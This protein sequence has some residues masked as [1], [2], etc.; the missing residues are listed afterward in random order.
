[1]Y[2]PINST[3]TQ[4]SGRKGRKVMGF[5]FADNLKPE[6]ACDLLQ[7]YSGW[8]HDST[9]HSRRPWLQGNLMSTWG[10]GNINRKQQ[11]E[12]SQ[13]WDWD[14]L[15]SYWINLLERP[16]D[17]RLQG[18]RRRREKAEQA[19]WEGQLRPVWGVWPHH[20]ENAYWT[21]SLPF[22][23]SEVIFTLIS[24]VPTLAISNLE[25]R[26]IISYFVFIY[27][28]LAGKGNKLENS[29]TWTD[30]GT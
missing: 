13:G 5:I 25:V 20:A 15:T 16:E 1:M 10:D 3:L 28:Y 18:S 29:D 19:T 14:D 26:T 2:V 27:I 6:R 11:P 23:N 17:L 8:H 22:E 9:R 12:T 4:W 24:L 30:L 7:E 21:S